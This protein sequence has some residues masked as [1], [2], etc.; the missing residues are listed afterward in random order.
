MFVFLEDPESKETELRDSIANRQ[1]VEKSIYTGRDTQNTERKVDYQSGENFLTEDY[2]YGVIYDRKKS[3]SQT[4]L[5]KESDINKSEHELMSP[6]TA[7]QL[8]TQNEEEKIKDESHENCETKETAPGNS[9]LQTELEKEPEICLNE[10]VLKSENLR[11]RIKEKKNALISENSDFERTLEE[12]KELLKAY[13]RKVELLKMT[14][15][16]CEKIKEKEEEA[17]LNSCCKL[18]NFCFNFLF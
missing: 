1:L 6:N 10:E 4:N 14:E 2:T 3:Y 17:A 8:D 11:I 12:Y 15:E 16:V 18:N 7:S 5:G 13:E 9:R